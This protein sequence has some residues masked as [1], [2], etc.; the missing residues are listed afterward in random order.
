MTPEQSEYLPELRRAQFKKSVDALNRN[1]DDL[2]WRGGRAFSIEEYPRDS[3]K[4]HEVPWGFKPFAMRDAAERGYRYLLWV[5]SSTR[6]KQSPEK[7][8]EIVAKRQALFF[9][10]FDG[11]NP[12]GEFSSDRALEIME[13]DRQVSFEIPIIWASVLGIDCHSTCA[14]QFLDSWAELA[15]PG[16]AFC[17]P[18]WSGVRGWPATASTDP[19]VKGH[20]HDQSVASILRHKL[21]LASPLPREVYDVYLYSDKAKFRSYNESN[22]STTARV[23]SRVSRLF[24]RHPA[25]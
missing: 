17:G 7:L 13:I 10:E 3:P 21:N 1:L 6:F 2:D 20:R 5:D 11:F 12:V 18:K 22:R 24:Q 15:V 23:I 19:R 4:H 9:N 14:K 25:S 16:G 8:F